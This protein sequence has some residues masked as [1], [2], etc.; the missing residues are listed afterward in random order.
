[1]SWQRD[2]DATGPSWEGN[3]AAVATEKRLEK[4][5]KEAQGKKWK[6]NSTKRY[7]PQSIFDNLD[8]QMKKL[9][10]EENEWLRLKKEA[11]TDDEKSQIQSHISTLRKRFWKLKDEYVQLKE[12]YKV[13]L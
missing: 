1:M 11:M 2:F 5:M 9:Y 10:A 12:N 7:I 3:A 13:T 6:E 4:K 8:E